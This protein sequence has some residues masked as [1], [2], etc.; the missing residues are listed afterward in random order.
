MNTQPNRDDEVEDTAFEPE[1]GPPHR[2]SKTPMPTTSVPVLPEIPEESI[3]R[4]SLKIAKRLGATKAHQ[5]HENA[6]A[7]RPKA[8]LSDALEM[9][10][11]DEEVSWLGKFRAEVPDYVINQVY[12]YA[13]RKRCTAAHLLLNM[14]R[15]YR[16]EKGHV[17]Y[18]RK[19]DCMV[20]DRRKERKEG[21]HD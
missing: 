1:N 5:T 11:D 15:S 19:K 9:P 18:I 3:E 20:T 7:V 2:P 4:M 13:H 17:F 8:P 21:R 6:H 14:M 10:L 12:E 16:D